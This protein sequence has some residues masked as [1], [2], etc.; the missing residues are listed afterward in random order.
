M[1]S[2][3]DFLKKYSSISNKFIDDFFDFYDNTS[4]DSDFLLDANN[5]CKWLEIR[6]DTLKKLLLETYKKNIDYTIEKIKKVKGSGSGA[7][8]KEK[9]LLTPNCFKKICQL[10][11]SKKGDE[12][13]EY[14]IKVE[15]TLFRYKNYIIEGLEEKIKKLEQNQKPKVYPK[16]GVIYVFETPNSPQNSLYKIGKTKD[17]KQRLKSHQSPLSHDINILY[18]FETEDIDSIEKCAKTFMKK[19]QYRKYKE[20]YQVN[21]DIIKEVISS[22]GKIPENIK[23]KENKDNKYFMH[24]SNEKV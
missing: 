4:I 9:I 8:T 15:E 19:Y 10:T 23:L 7:T 18:Y 3:K 11:K 14:F 20:V 24:I 13:R 5:I 2:I 21:I 17:L 12:V 16:R 6:K 1:L 22:C